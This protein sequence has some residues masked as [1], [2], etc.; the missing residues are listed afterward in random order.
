MEPMYEKT[1]SIRSYEVDMTGNVRPTALLNY[2]QEA[3]GDHARCLGVAVRDLLPQGLT[4]V[5]SRTHL[6]ILGPAASRE[7]VKVCTWPSSREGRFTC[8]EF[9]LT[10][11]DGRPLALATCSFAVLDL[12][13]RRPV[14]IDERLPNYPLLTRR[15]IPDDFATIPRLAKADIELTFR[16]GR[17]DLDIN[18]HANNVAYAAW[19]LESVPETVAEKAILVDLEIAYRAEIFHGQSVIA[20]SRRVDGDGSLSFLHQLVREGDGVELTRLVSC[21][22]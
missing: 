1:F 17:E 21:W 14:I 3:A 2:L 7:E 9:E 15:A 19:A 20:R 5:L 11:A 18:R 12:V 16:V 22:Q 13:T 6:K 10:V 4:W 8:R